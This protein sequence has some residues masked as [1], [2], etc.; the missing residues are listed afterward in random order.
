MLYGLGIVAVIGYIANHSAFTIVANQPQQ[1][2]EPTASPPPEP[3][4][5]TSQLSPV[6]IPARSPIQATAPQSAPSAKSKEEDAE[7]AAVKMFPALGIPGSSLNEKF[8]E[9]Y[10][11]LRLESPRFF[12]DPSWPLIL[13]KSVAESVIPVKEVAEQER[14]GGTNNASARQELPS[15]APLG[16]S[17]WDL[18]VINKASAKDIAHDIQT[19]GDSIPAIFDTTESSGT[20]GWVHDIDFTHQTALEITFR[21]ALPDDT[22]VISLRL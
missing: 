19:Y 4:A 1:V 10:R 14:A 7:A 8:R 15:G 16:A 21:G 5:P 9:E 18:T 20:G 12:D 13:A 6:A 11:R 22:T 17:F 2:T 3:A